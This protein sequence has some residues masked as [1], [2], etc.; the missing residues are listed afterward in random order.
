MECAIRETSEELGVQSHPPRELGVLRFQFTDGLA[1]EC[2][3]FRADGCDGTATETEE[4]APLWTPVDRIPVDEMWADD[5]FW[6]PY[7]LED[8]P[9]RGW[10][11]FAGDE[12]L[13]RRVEPG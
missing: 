4:A 8:K 11:V 10:F 9:F 5:R 13:T 6:L 12:M 7:L 1:L 3:V 2:H